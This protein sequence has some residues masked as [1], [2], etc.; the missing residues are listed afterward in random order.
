MGTSH[1]LPDSRLSYRRW[2]TATSHDDAGR[3]RLLPPHRE[4]L[5]VERLHLALAGLLLLG[6]VGHV[7][8]GPWR[9]PRQT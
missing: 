8:P 1:A 9:Q 6:V 7:E 5:V 2:K 3:G 4:V